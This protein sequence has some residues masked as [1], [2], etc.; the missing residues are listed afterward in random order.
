MTMFLQ[1]EIQELQRTQRR[2]RLKRLLRLLCSLGLL[3][4]VVA[5][6]TACSLAGS[7]SRGPIQP[8]YRHASVDPL[9][10]LDPVN[11]VLPDR[12]R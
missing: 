4:G 10:D 9:G 11:Q 8:T 3:L 7:T 12:V 5:Y 2:R 6:S 1:I